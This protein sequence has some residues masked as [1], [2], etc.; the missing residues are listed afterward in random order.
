MYVSLAQETICQTKRTKACK[1]VRGRKIRSLGRRHVY[2][3]KL[4]NSL[5]VGDIYAALHNKLHQYPTEVEHDDEVSLYLDWFIY[6]L[7]HQSIQGGKTQDSE[8]APL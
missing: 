6:F 1:D 8:V 5:T 2:S 4:V 3:F 7:W